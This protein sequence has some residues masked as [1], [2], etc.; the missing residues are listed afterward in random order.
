MA[1]G[2]M[3]ITNVPSILLLSGVALKCFKDYERQR[4][5][6]KNPVFKA[7]NIGLFDKLDFWQ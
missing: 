4:K 5:E 6:G 7:A 2:L 1:Q 3:V